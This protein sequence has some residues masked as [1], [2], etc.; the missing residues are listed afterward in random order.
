MRLVHL[1]DIH[2]GGYG[3][4]WDPDEDQRIQLT[5]DV[6]RLVAE[7][8]PV[9]AVLVG[10]DI[11][12]KAA[13]GEYDQAIAWL[14]RTAEAASC[15][16]S[17]VWVVPGNHDVDRG[18]HNRSVVRR[19]MSEQLGA[20]PAH[21]VDD[22]MRG[23]MSCH[24]HDSTLARAAML[25]ALAQAGDDADSILAS[26]LDGMVNDGLFGCFDAYNTFAREWGVCTTSALEPHWT[27]LTLD[28]EGLPVQLTGLNTA[29]ISDTR[30]DPTNGARLL[31]GDHQCK[32]NGGPDRVSI[33]FGHHPPSWIRDWPQV[34]PY[35][36]RAHILLFGHLHEYKAVQRDPGGTVEIYAGAVG[37]DR[38]DDPNRRFAPSWNLI[39][40]TRDGDELIVNVSPRVWFQNRVRFDAHSDGPDTFRVL[41]DLDGVSTSGAVALA[42]ESTHSGTNASP[43]IPSMAEVIDGA[44]LPEPR[45][46]S[47]RRDL[48]VEFLRLA[49]TVQLEIANDLGVDGDLDALDPD[50]TGIEILRRVRGKDLIDELARSMPDA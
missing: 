36:R 48:A 38:T 50:E 33:A 31:L 24:L 41:V 15:P 14:E 25:A 18:L 21:A 10:G 7:G 16:K 30:D 34:E 35:L 26:W 22:T 3:P 28:V 12:F 2:F 45:E 5:R 23:W 13:P 40:V 11:A 1:S 39:T 42:S 44:G 29:V 8:G 9:D 19:A 47:R 4:G 46:R 17:Q 27:E 32:L 43:L 6:E 37:P 49:T 20:A